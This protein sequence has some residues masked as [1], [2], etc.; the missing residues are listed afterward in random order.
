MIDMGHDD[1]AIQSALAASEL[2]SS[3]LPAAPESAHAQ[4]SRVQLHDPLVPDGQAF[5]L[6]AA[7]VPELDVW[8]ASVQSAGLEDA[9]ALDLPAF[10][11][12][13]ERPEEPARVMSASALSAPIALAGSLCSQPALLSDRTALQSD[14][15]LGVCVS[16]ELFFDAL[17]ELFVDDTNNEFSCDT[18]TVHFHDAMEQICLDVP[19]CMADLS[20]SVPP[21]SAKTARRNARRAWEAATKAAHKART[22]ANKGSNSGSFVLGS[23]ASLLTFL[24]GCLLVSLLG[25]AAASLHCESA[26]GSVARALSGV[27]SCVDRRLGVRKFV[28][29]ATSDGFSIGAPPPPGWEWAAVPVDSGC[30]NSIFTSVTSLLSLR[31]TSVRIASA[32][33]N[34]TR[35]GH[36]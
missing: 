5:S 6:S 12:A 22:R 17:E 15:P 31:P 28:V 1:H 32:D 2:A 26:G 33:G 24:C 20:E 19:M 23:L 16:G 27:S 13:Y 8:A 3:E 35:T 30:T 9:A 25:G 4:L 7:A 10:S 29:P 18:S 21:V 36:C 34:V 11:D 14:S